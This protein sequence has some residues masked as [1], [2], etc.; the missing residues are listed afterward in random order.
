VVCFNLGDLLTN[1]FGHPELGKLQFGTNGEGPAIR[2]N[3]STPEAFGEGV[4]V[5]R[6]R[7]RRPRLGFVKWH[8]SLGA[9]CKEG[10]K[11]IT[12]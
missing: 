9:F 1:S 3:L 7:R 10:A 12:L 2:P 8:K 4:A 11:Y 6:R 5:H